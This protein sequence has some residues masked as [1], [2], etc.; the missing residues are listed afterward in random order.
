M[1]NKHTFDNISRFSMQLSLTEI[2]VGSFLHAFRIPFSGFFLSLNQCFVLNRALLSHGFPTFRAGRAQMHTPALHAGLTT[3]R[4]Y[5]GGAAS[6]IKFPKG[7]VVHNASFSIPIF[8]PMTISNTAAILKTL[9]PYGKKFIPMLAISMQGILFTLG[10]IV[11]G[12]NIVGRC[13]GSLLLSFWPMVQPLIV[14]WII[15][16]SLL[17]SMADYYTKILAKFPIIQHLTIQNIV[18]IYIAAH[19]LLSVAVCLLASLLPSRVIDTYDRFLLSYSSLKPQSS[20]PATTFLSRIRGAC[21]DCIS[22]IFILSLLSVGFFLYA[23]LN[24][25]EAFFLSF[26]R[27]IAI[28]FVTFFVLRN[29]SPKWCIRFFSKIFFFKRY[30]PYVEE[31]MHRIQGVSALPSAPH[32]ASGSAHTSAASPYQSIHLSQSAPSSLP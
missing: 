32:T 9:S 27:I 17:H 28:A 5:R 16:G 15:Y 10:T 29:I 31:V 26:F 1:I 2:G 21:K 25:L 6:S 18:V 22:P 24:S 20:T 13:V 30:T 14:F 4:H 11:C 3:D 12:R 23:T 7:S 8:L 19:M